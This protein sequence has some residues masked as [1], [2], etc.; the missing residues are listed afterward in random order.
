MATASGRNS[1]ASRGRHS[2]SGNPSSTT[3]VAAA[4]RWARTGRSATNS[5]E[6]LGTGC[7]SLEA[8]ST[9]RRLPL[10]TQAGPACSSL[11]SPEKK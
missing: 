3:K 10:V 11:A 8:Y 2:T 7:W 1:H 4:N 9:Q 6:G 5:A